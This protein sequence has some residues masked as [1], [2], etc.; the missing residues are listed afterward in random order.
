[1]FSKFYGFYQSRL[2]QTPA[3]CYLHML[4]AAISLAWLPTTVQTMNG[5]LPT[6][7]LATTIV[8][9]CVPN[10]LTKKNTDEILALNIRHSCK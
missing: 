3:A 4:T 2:S 5:L 6:A 7:L 10:I 9:P 8:C 1:M